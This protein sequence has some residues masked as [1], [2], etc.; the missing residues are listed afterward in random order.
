MSL[1]QKSFIHKLSWSQTNKTWDKEHDVLQSFVQL[2]WFRF[3]LVD[4]IGQLPDLHNVVLGNRANDPKN[5]RINFASNKLTNQGSLGFHEKSEILAV[6]PPWMN[7]NSGGPSSASSALCS[8]PIL[9]KSQ[10]CKRRSVPL[11]AKIVSLCGD[12][13]TWKISSRCDS[14]ECSFNFRFL[15]SQRATV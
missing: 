1:K 8:S 3:F 14:N 2:Q 7:N 10:M 6:W 13:W 9:L 11:E 4:R 15:K 5:V 12:H